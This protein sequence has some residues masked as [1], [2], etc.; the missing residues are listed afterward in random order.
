MEPQRASAGA[1][2]VGDAAAADDTLVDPWD[3]CFA[4]G[5]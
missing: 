2:V 5:D 1:Q 4:G 3:F